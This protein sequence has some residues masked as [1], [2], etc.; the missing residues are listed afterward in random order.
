MCL[1]VQRGLELVLCL[2]VSHSHS[3][4]EVTDGVY[5]EVELVGQ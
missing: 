2:K 1:V 3:V 4:K 5:I